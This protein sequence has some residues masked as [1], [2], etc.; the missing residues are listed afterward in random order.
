MINT[1]DLIEI[2]SILQKGLGSEE[3]FEAVFELLERTV[4]FESATLFV[5]H[6]DGDRLEIVLKRG[7][8]VVDLA[9]SIAFSR[10]KGISSFISKQKKP[11]ILE[12]LAK[13]RPGKLNIFS[14]FV[15]MPL[16]IGERLIGVLNLGHNEPGIYKKDSIEE[17]SQLASQVSVVMDKLNLRAKLDEQNRLLKQT[18]DELTATQD[19]LVE[20]KRLAA[21]GEI[22]VTVNHRINNPLT[23]IMNHAQLLPMMIETRNQKKA[24]NAANK[25]YEPARQIS[26]V[27]HRLSE[28]DA[29]S[30]ESYLNGV[31]MIKLAP[32]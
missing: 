8:Y 20:K 17:F 22:V 10:G 32:E 31:E 24:K 5:Y 11:I 30:T 29:T 13:S 21:I 7:E 19:E 25:I 14:S 4:T 3:T 15:S 12:S 1:K 26:D 9:E 18:L 23:T 28:I 27:T 2:G 6:E 16:W